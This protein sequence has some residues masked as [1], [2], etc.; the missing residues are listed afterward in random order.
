[1]THRV[2]VGLNGRLDLNDRRC[3]VIGPKAKR[4]RVRMID[5][6]EEVDLKSECLMTDDDW[7]AAWTRNVLERVCHDHSKWEAVVDRASKRVASDAVE[8]VITATMKAREQHR[9]QHRLQ[10][11]FG[12]DP[13]KEL[14]WFR[15]QCEIE[16]LRQLPRGPPQALSDDEI[17]VAFGNGYVHDLFDQW[18]EQR[19]T[20][21]KIPAW[22]YWHLA[23]EKVL[24]PIKIRNVS[25]YW[26]ELGNGRKM[27][28]GGEQMDI[29]RVAFETDCNSIWIHD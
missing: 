13:A 29:D 17:I 5:S 2:V 7:A 16:R 27:A 21:E 22:F 19:E 11:F 28:P 8:A 24:F 15:R 12:G 6:G 23:K 10:T 25:N 3:D 14:E 9:R 26:N 18:H 4:L 20:R 1:M